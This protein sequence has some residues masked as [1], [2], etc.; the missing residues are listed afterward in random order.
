M[1]Y[2]LYPV[3]YEGQEG[4]KYKFRSMVADVNPFLLN[5]EKKEFYGSELFSVHYKNKDTIFLIV[6]ETSTDDFEI[7]ENFY[8]PKLGKKISKKLLFNFKYKKFLK[9][10][11]LRILNGK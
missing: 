3:S 2:S 5:K 4:N 11:I 10:R 9:E 8:L 1:D 7:I 6:V